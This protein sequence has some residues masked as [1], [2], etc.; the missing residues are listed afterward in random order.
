MIGLPPTAG[1][2]SKWYLALGSVENGQ[3]WLV[4]VLLISTLMNA[5]YFVRIFEQVYL[6]PSRE[7]A[8]GRAAEGEAPSPML[9]PTLVF[10]ALLLVLGV[11]N[12]AIIERVLQPMLGGLS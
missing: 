4:A 9:A 12:A 10:G 5:V 3:W 7:G 1:F 11:M 2:F 8:A 6:R